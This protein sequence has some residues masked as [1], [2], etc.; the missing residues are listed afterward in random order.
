MREYP[1]NSTSV[2]CAVCGGN[3]PAWGR[4]CPIRQKEAAKMKAKW[5][6][7]AKYYKVLERKT[8]P[9]PIM[10]FT[11]GGPDA[12]G[13]RTVTNKRKALA[14]VTDRVQ[15]TNT[16]KKEPERPTKLSTLEQ[17]QKPLLAS[18]WSQLIE[19]TTPAATRE[20]KIN[21]ECYEYNVV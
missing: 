1:K 18:T 7:K 12:E 20:V 19:P 14:D 15:N 5:E 8:T 2:K 6:T 13:F 10:R 16:I 11:T 3:Y 17:G 4:D 9:L 21:T